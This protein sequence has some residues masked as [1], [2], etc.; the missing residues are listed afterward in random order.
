MAEK[1]TSTWLFVFALSSAESIKEIFGKKNTHSG[2]FGPVQ[3]ARRGQGD[4]SRWRNEPLSGFCR[5]FQFQP[6]PP[7]ADQAANRKQFFIVQRS[8]ERCL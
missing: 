8:C 3:S 4:P 2:Y 6:E 7:R 5:R 1:K